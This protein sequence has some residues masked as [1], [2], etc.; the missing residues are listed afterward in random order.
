MRV[1]GYQVLLRDKVAD[2]YYVKVGRYVSAAC[3]LVKMR[4]KDPRGTHGV[5]A[6]TR[7]A[8]DEPQHHE[9]L[10]EHVERHYDGLSD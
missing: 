6:A 9:V 3:P 1:G 4:V 10:A 8:L 2:T 7:A 5:L